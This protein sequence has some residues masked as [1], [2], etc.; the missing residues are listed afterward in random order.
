MAKGLPDFFFFLQPMRNHLN[1]M[2]I[3]FFC[4]LTTSA[5]H[6]K[7][8]HSLEENNTIESWAAWSQAPCFQVSVIV[9]VEVGQGGRK[10]ELTAEESGRRSQD[11]TCL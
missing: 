6:A 2:N 3:Q 10:T 1:T 4:A 7:H 9:Q 5:H 8:T 11:S